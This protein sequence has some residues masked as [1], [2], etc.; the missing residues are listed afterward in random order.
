MARIPDF[1]IVGAAKSGTTSLWHYLRQHPDVFMPANKEPLYFA[2]PYY[3]RMPDA[4]PK[5]GLLRRCLVADWDAYLRLF[6]PAGDRRAAGEASQPYL[7][8]H[9][10]TI[11][12]IRERLGDPRI[13]IVLRNPVE[14]AV[15]AY[16]FLVRDGE[17]PR[18]LDE[19]LDL[20]E[21]RIRDGWSMSHFY[22]AA[23]LY[24]AQVKA[25]RDGFSRVGVWLYDDLK[26]DAS[27]FVRS[28]YEFLGVD[29]AF[30]PDVE[31]RHNISGIPTN[32]LVLWALRDTNPL[33]L[34]ARPFARLLFPEPVRRRIVEGLRARHTRR[35]EVPPETR[36]RLCALFRED[37]LR[38][39]DTIGRDLS[40]W[41]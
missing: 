40:A 23:G 22:R 6:E 32:R 8:H 31:T 33:R 19:C 39:Q 27:A 2:A 1:L 20:E 7:Y 17:E 28:L 38:L 16:T 9:E 41:L 25:Y 13:L 4:D 30:Q 21:R 29:P 34:A 5:A 35:M 3:E 18:S 37:I 15:S 36:A 11:P 24:A 26:S 12:R 14:R 10:I